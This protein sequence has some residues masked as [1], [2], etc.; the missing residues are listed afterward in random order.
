VG[1]YQGLCGA[2]QANHVGMG[3]WVCGFGFFARGHDHGEGAC[4]SKG[5]GVRHG[6]G[7]LL[8]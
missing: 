6:V 2:N 8:S 3:K 7:Y 4:L 1:D 5:A